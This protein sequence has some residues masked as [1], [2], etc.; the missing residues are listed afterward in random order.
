MLV[1]GRLLHGLL[2]RLELSQPVADGASLLDAEINRLVLLLGVERS[3][4]ITL[5]LVDD[6]EDASNGLADNSAEESRTISN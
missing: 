5:L 6:G 2:V 4:G 3:G 1:L